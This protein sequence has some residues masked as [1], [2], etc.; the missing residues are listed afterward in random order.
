ML[1]KYKDIIQSIDEK[2]L[3]KKP[4]NVL[5]I[6]SSM[7]KMGFEID[8]EFEE[9]IKK[10]SQLIKDEKMQDM[11][12]VLFDILDSSQS[13]RYIEYMDK[14]NV[15]DKVFPQIS[16]MK[17][18][19]ECKYHVVDSLKHSIYTLKE[20]ESV[21]SETDFFEKHIEK[22]IREHLNQK[23]GSYSRITLL[24]LGALFHDIGKV[25]T[26]KVDE[27]GRVRFRGHE[28]AGADIIFE[29]GLQFGLAKEE[30]EIL[31]R[32]VRYH[33]VL[34]ILYKENDVSKDRLNE[35]FKEVGDEVLDVLLVGYADI[36]ATRRLL[37][38]SEEFGMYKIYLEYIAN[39]Y[40]T[41]YKK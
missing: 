1:V 5:K 21:L 29:M 41:R 11:A 30:L 18:V 2:E 3:I 37:N 15:L 26:K 16:E 32:I 24:K 25:A 31:K 39:N 7:A 20:L 8:L 38:P 35:F 19:G 12:R 27:D 28:I 4:I 9:A 17:N 36:V 33:M 34:L 23:I 6:I 14:L 10:N 40:L 13:H 22:N